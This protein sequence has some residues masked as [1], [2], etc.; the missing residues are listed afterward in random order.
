MDSFPC[1]LVRLLLALGRGQTYVGCDLQ[2]PTWGRAEHGGDSRKVP[3]QL[4]S[5]AHTV[6]DDGW[7]IFLDAASGLPYYHH[8][9]SGKAQWR[10]PEI[11]A[12]EA[13]E[14]PRGWEEFFDAKTG[15]P[16]FHHAASGKTQW[17]RPAVGDVVA[18]DT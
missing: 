9:A 1:F 4:T 6:V 11:S 2:E 13:A 8:A 18:A 16:Y 12:Q 15:L 3:A 10:R 17:A 14:L 7:K 5:A